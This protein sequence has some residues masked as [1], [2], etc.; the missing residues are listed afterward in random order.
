MSNIDDY[1]DSVKTAY[2]KPGGN[3]W[4]A[5]G[6]QISNSFITIA[7]LNQLRQLK[8]TRKLKT[9]QEIADLFWSTTQIRYILTGE[10][11]IGLKISERKEKKPNI[12]EIT[13]NTQY[14]LNLL[15][16][17][18]TDDSFCLKGS[19][20]IL[21]EKQVQE[22]TKSKKWHFSNK[23]AMKKATVSTSAV[24]WA[25]GYDTYY[26]NFMEIHGPYNIGKKKQLLV[27]EYNFYSI[28]D[29]WP[30]AP[31]MPKRLRY[32]LIYDNNNITI[33]WELHHDE[34]AELVLEKYFAVEI[35]DGEENELSDKELEALVEKNSQIVQEQVERVN[36]LPI[37]EKVRKGALLVHLQTKCL[38]DALGQGWK[39]SKE[40]EERISEKGLEEWNAPSIRP[41]NPDLAAN[42]I[43]RFDPRIPLPT[44]CFC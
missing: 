2:S 44:R 8:E 42:W 40:V 11:V 28:K 21:T 4:P 23:Q 16:L 37:L 19:N 34:S 10:F 30:E 24:A 29:V 35:N 39:P 12:K 17:K 25:F 6:K 3:D 38:A 9:D 7:A 43:T 32:Y 41:K 18:T 31:K 1:L 5:K 27:R 14:F 20:K 26:P 15:K 22:I 36:N 33:D 13:E